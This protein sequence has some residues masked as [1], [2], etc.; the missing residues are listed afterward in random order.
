MLIY[1]GTNMMPSINDANPAMG[2]CAAGQH[3]GCNCPHGTSCKIIHE[4]DIAKWP[5]TT[6]AKQSA[7]DNQMLALEWNRKVV[8]PAKVAAFITKLAA[9][10]LA[11]MTST[12]AKL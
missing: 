5:V 7:L 1:T 2:L 8:D 10:S 4:L 3:M 9:T 6:F 12:K 11:C